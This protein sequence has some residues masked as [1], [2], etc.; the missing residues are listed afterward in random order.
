MQRVIAAI[1]KEFLQFSRDRMLI[2]LILFTYTIEVVI[3]TYALT[4]DVKN[5][6]LGVYDQDGSQLSRTLIEQFTR[7]EYF[8]HAEYVSDPR[9][10]DRLLDEGQIEMGVI[11]P[12]EFSDLVRKGRD[13]EVQVILSGTNSNT[14]NVAMGYAVTILNG[15]SRE[16]VKAALAERGLLLPV[17]AVD[18]QPRI[19]YPALDFRYFMVISMIVVAGLLVGIVHAASSMVREKETGTI[20]QIIIT[21][22][23]R[24][25]IIFAK[26][27]PTFT[28]G[29][30]SLVPSLLIAAWFK[31]PMKGSIALFFLASAVSLFTSIGIGIFISTLSRNLQQTLLLSFFFIFPVMFLS[32][33]LVPIESMP[34]AMQYLSYLSPVRYHMQIALGIFLKGTGLVVLWPQFLA[35][36]LFGMVIFPLSLVR[37]RKHF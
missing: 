9:F 19:W 14:A 34:P 20:E 13:A 25:E 28:V 1:R 7:S 12:P 10:I 11:I 23:R 37:L 17:P 29:M 33:T 4:F 36:A 15:F 30:V 21:P 8:S 22:L 32:G 27:V 26:I 35:M 24:H 5:L 3:C 2:F 16:A 6:R 18:L 31:L